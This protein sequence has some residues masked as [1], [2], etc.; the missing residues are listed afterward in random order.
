MKTH[1]TMK[2]KIHSLRVAV[3]LLMKITMKFH[4]Q[5][6]FLYGEFFAA[7]ANPNQI[8]SK[9]RKLSQWITIKNKLK[10][11]HDVFIWKKTIE[12]GWVGSW[13]ESIC[14][15]CTKCNFTHRWKCH[16]YSIRFGMVFEFYYWI[17]LP[18]HFL[19]TQWM[20]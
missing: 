17:L 10:S 6:A 16:I 20:K 19:C 18:W 11:S 3:S 15:K 4:L 1:A 9:N 5:I 8:Y 13:P 7:Y 14:W 12:F 2:Y